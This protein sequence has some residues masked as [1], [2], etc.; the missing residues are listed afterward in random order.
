MKYY[1]GNTDFDWYNYLKKISPEDINFWQPSGLVHFRAIDKGSPFLLKLKSP[2]NKIAGIGFFTSHSLLP[3]EFA[4]EVFQNR[5]GTQQF[6][7]FYSKIKSYRNSA[8][9]IEKNPNIGCIILTDPIFFNE[10]DWIKIPE[11]WSRNIV[12]GKT[13]D[14]ENENDKVYWQIVEKLLLKYPSQSLE[15]TRDQ[16][17]IYNKYMTNVRIGQ[18]AFRVLVTDAYSRRCAISGEKTLPVLEAAHIKPYSTSGN[19]ATYNGMLLRSDLHK[20]FDS[21]YIT[22]T[23]KYLIEI[24]KKIKEE[25]ENGRDYYKY[26]G[27]QLVSL[28]S[29]KYDLP[30]RENLRWHNE[31]CF[32]K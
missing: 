8:N 29:S 9:P 16:I 12:Q 2:I 22:V 10:Q 23:D 20:L 27:Q 21:G 11:N 14:T 6:A 3:I 4:W 30:D 17:P 28:P 18:G 19:N 15:V 5:N 24:S 1:I 25:F 32:K 13:Y 31:N 26:H 7:D